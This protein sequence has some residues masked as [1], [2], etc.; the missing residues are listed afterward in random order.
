MKK[1]IITVMLVAAITVSAMT[2]CS[3]TI[4]GSKEDASAESYKSGFSDTS[5]DEI[6]SEDASSEQVSSTSPVNVDD[7]DISN[8]WSSWQIAVDGDV[9]TMP[10]DISEFEKNGWK[11]EDADGT[12]KANQYTLGNTMKKGD[13]SISVQIVNMSDKEIDVADGKVGRVKVGLDSKVSTVL[14]GK[15]VF[16]ENLTIEDIKAKY[17]EPSSEYDSDKSVTLS[18]TDKLYQSV[19]FSIYNPDSGLTDHST[20]SVRNFDVK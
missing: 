14:P 4:G 20:V 18:Y 16:D 3:V 1:K 17:G 9:Y 13:L 15:L 10:C 6:S 19:E 8:D 12:L 5:S 7:I 11:L 2:S